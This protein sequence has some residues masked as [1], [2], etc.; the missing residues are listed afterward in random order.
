MFFFSLSFF[1]LQ[2]NNVRR[3][4]NTTA[5]VAAAANS[6]KTTTHQSVGHS[7]CRLGQSIF[8]SDATLLIFTA[9]HRATEFLLQRNASVVSSS[10]SERTKS[11]TKSNASPKETLMDTES[12]RWSE[13]VNICFAIQRLHRKANRNRSSSLRKTFGTN[14]KASISF[15]FSGPIES[16]T[17][18][19]KN[20]F[21]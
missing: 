19:T 4:T 5:P 13:W 18:N 17:K 7:Q 2:L 14:D 9:T 10:Q 1:Q 8:S 6:N 16:F 12:L 15:K 3:I 11:T 20:R 21:G